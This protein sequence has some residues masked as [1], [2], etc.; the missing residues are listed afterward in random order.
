MFWT[1]LC[2]VNLENYFKNRHTLDSFKFEIFHSVWDSQLYPFLIH[3]YIIFIS[4][5][6]PNP[7][8]FFLTLFLPYL[9]LWERQSGKN[10][11][12]ET[13]KMYLLL[14]FHS[15]QLSTHLDVRF[16]TMLPN[17][18]P[19]CKINFFNSHLAWNAIV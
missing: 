12:R 4:S 11:K 3:W 5:C 17:Y 16:L 1:C 15:Y 2:G 10:E 19:I 18:D 7:I 9:W 13:F 6:F 8:W 14:H